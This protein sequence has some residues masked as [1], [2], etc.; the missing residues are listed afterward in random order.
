M[1]RILIE[2]KA[3]L[4][5]G[6]WL[7]WLEA[8]GVSQSTAKTLMQIGDKF[9][10]SQHAGYLGFRVLQL[11]SQD[12]TPTDQIRYHSALLNVRHIGF[13]VLVGLIFFILSCESNPKCDAR[14]TK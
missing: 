13:K 1:G 2:Q 11:L 10:N 12:S 6:L 7:K 3:D 5:H 8:K 14:F 4:Q 9:S